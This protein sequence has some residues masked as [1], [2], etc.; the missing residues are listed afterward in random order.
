MSLHSALLDP[1]CLVLELGG[2]PQRRALTVPQNRRR[3]RRRGEQQSKTGQGAVQCSAYVQVDD[4]QRDGNV[5]SQ[6]AAVLSARHRIPILVWDAPSPPMGWDGV[7]LPAR[8]LAAPIELTSRMVDE[9]KRERERWDCGRWL[10]WYAWG[11]GEVVGMGKARKGPSLFCGRQ[12]AERG[13]RRGKQGARVVVATSTRSYNCSACILA[14][15]SIQYTFAFSVAGSFL[16]L[17][18]LSRTRQRRNWACH[19][20]TDG[21]QSSFIQTVDASHA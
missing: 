18:L 4:L 21:G 20:E 9:G 13:Q 12:R 2:G 19:R 10:C 16:H 8:F 1:P 7:G 5:F 11:L 17:H 3:R 15:C 14:A 6:P